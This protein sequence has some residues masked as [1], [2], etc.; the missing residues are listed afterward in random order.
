MCVFVLTENYG[1]ITLFRKVKRF[2]T[3][4]NSYINVQWFKNGV[5][6]HFLLGGFFN[7]IRN[8][9]TMFFEWCS[10]LRLWIL[11][12]CHP[13]FFFKFESSHDM[14]IASVSQTPQRMKR[15]IRCSDEHKGWS[16]TLIA[17]AISW[18]S[19][20][21]LQDQ[22]GKRRILFSYLCVQWNT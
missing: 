11:N 12:G 22:F 6:R 7:F 20:I 15:F 9:R 13:N 3:C 2:K 5:F 18:Q 10:N 19:Y 14:T 8:V 21:S 4:T 16:Y 17:E 1:E